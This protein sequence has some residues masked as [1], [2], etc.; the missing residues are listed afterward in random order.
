MIAG[1]VSNKR[2]AAREHLVIMWEI[3]CVLPHNRLGT[4]RRCA[5]QHRDW[6]QYEEAFHLVVRAQRF[7]K[8]SRSQVVAYFLVYTREINLTRNVSRA[9]ENARPDQG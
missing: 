8:L 6:L 1:H 4:P 3:S 7:S 9:W 5:L 2:V